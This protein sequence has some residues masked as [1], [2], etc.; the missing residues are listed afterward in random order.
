MQQLYFLIASRLTKPRLPTA[1]LVFPVPAPTA[2][3]YALHRLTV[4]TA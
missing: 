2:A 4:E 3:D 1:K